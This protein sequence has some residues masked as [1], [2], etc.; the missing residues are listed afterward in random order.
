MSE[1]MANSTKPALMLSGTQFTLSRVL[2]PPCTPTL[3]LCQ[4]NGGVA[5]GLPPNGVRELP[6]FS[7]GTLPRQI[8]RGSVMQ[9]G[10]RWPHIYEVGWRAKAEKGV[11]LK[12]T[13]KRKLQG[14]SRTTC[15]VQSILRMPTIITTTATTP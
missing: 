5:I 7:V 2:L 14:T 6:M 4:W 13:L 12:Q 3:I 15:I 9:F 11:S 8:G 1:Q 10:F